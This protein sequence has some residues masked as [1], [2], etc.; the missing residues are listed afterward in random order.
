MAEATGVTSEGR[1]SIA[2]PGLWNEDQVTAWRT[3]TD[4]IHSQ[5][6]KTGIQI[7]H[8]G[9]K[10]STMR[11]WD[12]HVTASKAEGG[13]ETVGP[14]AIAFDGYPAP[15]AMTIE[16]IDQLVQDFA[17][18]ADR[19]LRAGFDLI[20][21]HAAHGYLMHQFLSPLSNQRTD[22]YGGSLENRSRIL[23]RVVHA[24]RARVGEGVPLFVRLSASDWTPGGWDIDESVLL[25]KALREAGVDLMDVSSGGNV[26]N[27]TIPQGPGYQVH[28][29]EAIRE[30]ASIP[31]S[32]VGMIS[33]PAQAEAILSEGRADAVMLA[34]A[35]LR[36][37]RWA[38]NA[39]ESLGEII[40][41]PIQLDRART[42]RRP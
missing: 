2:C 39:A 35:Y 27:A 6:T 22:D 37:P 16:E 40:S 26:A 9:R 33:D 32:S 19:A 34:R 7:S 8:A 24:V 18:A 29:A 38:I 11:P 15:R 10:A 17:D 12:D 28:F 4:F 42:L 14:S 41:W 23:L 5:G 20:E 36:N 13:W 3:V 21:I 31:T 30:Q 25:S 1:I